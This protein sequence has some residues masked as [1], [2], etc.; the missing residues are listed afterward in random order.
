MLYERMKDLFKK[1]DVYIPLVDL[2]RRESLKGM[3]RFQQL[4]RGTYL[5]KTEKLKNE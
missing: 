1:E 4:A 3:F 5:P 2:Q